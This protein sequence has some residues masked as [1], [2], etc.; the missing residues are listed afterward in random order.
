[1]EFFYTEVGGCV[2][3]K[4][5]ALN[6]RKNKLA[7]HAVAVPVKGLPPLDAQNMYAAVNSTPKTRPPRIEPKQTNA[8]VVC[9]PL[10]SE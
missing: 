1:M 7:S 5:L 6:R 8:P 10:E 3:A 4:R 2:T 9:C